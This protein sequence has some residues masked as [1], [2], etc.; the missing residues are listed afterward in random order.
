MKKLRQIK[1]S[2][3]KLHTYQ[4]Q[5]EKQQNFKII[6]WISQIIKQISLTSWKQLFPVQSSFVNEGTAVKKNKRYLFV[7]TLKYEVALFE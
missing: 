7:E 4:N 6:N 2:T 3:P 1:T 5:Q